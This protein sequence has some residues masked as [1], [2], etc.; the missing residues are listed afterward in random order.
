MGGNQKNVPLPKLVTKPLMSF[1]KLLEGGVLPVHEA[2]KYYK[3]AMQA[4]KEFLACVCTP[5]KVLVNQICIKHLRKVNDSRNHL[6]QIIK[7]IIFLG[8]QNMPFCGHRDDET[9][10][11]RSN[12]ASLTLNDGNFREILRFRE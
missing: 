10:L 3:E 12:E 8:H 2:N 4:G 7:S 6:F 11:E 1:A 5:G 9:L